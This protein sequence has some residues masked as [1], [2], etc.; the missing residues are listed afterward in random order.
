MVLYRNPKGYEV[1]ENIITKVEVNTRML[2]TLKNA[3]SILSMNP[4]DVF[5]TSIVVKI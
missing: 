5:E 3:E 2:S 4:G 1:A